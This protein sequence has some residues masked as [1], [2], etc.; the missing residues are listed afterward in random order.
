MQ[1]WVC[2]KSAP[3][4]AF[5]RRPL[6][7]QS[8]G[9]STGTSAAPSTRLTSPA[10]AVPLGSLCSLRMRCAM[11]SKPLLSRSNTGLASGWS[12]VLG[13]SP[14]SIS[15]LR[16]PSETAPRMSPCSARRLRSRQVIWKIG[17]MPFWTR[18]CAAARLERCTLAPAPSVTLT[19]VIRPFSGSA[20]LRNSAGSVDTGGV[21][22]A[23]TTKSPACS[24]AWRLL[25]IYDP[26]LPE[27]PDLTV[28]LESLAARISNRRLLRVRL[29]NPFLL[30]TA[31]PPISAAEGRQVA[32]LSRL[33]KRIV[34]ALEGELYLVLHLMVAG[35]LRWDG[36]TRRS[37]TLAHLDFDSG[38]LTVTEAGSKRR[39]S[40]HLVQGGAALAAM[41][42]GGI[43]VLQ[44]SL[45]QFAARLASENHTLKRSLT[46]PRLFAGIG[47]AYSDEI[48]H[49]AKLSPI[50]MTKDL[51]P[52]QRE[53]L[54]VST[55]EVLNEWT[56]RLRTRG[57]PDT[58]SVLRE[59][60]A[61]D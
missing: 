33:G 18:K 4:A 61:G 17:S 19:A 57:F 14:A 20:R 32:G 6:G 58:V 36:K 30:R 1:N 39:A 2:T 60:L 22:S 47:N 27:L 55:I 59:G 24:F 46:D 49:R 42:P 12:P 43:E 8:G 40:L 16:M 3:A 10:I 9:G 41:D 53:R 21:I 31:V 28:Y 56:E 26:T 45:A 34:I 7:S 29:L 37:I 23:V 44:S 15:M 52:E 35:R 50:A 54:Y 38:T 5:A 11:A 51:L 13:S 25:A 48:L